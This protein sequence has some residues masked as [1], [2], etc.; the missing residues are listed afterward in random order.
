MK[1]LYLLR[2]RDT[3]VAIE[4]FSRVYLAILAHKVIYRA[5]QGVTRFEAI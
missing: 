3:T 5:L 4:G 2:E 1:W